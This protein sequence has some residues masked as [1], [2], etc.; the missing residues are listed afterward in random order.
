MSDPAEL[1]VT[2]YAVEA[3]ARVRRYPRRLR[4]NDLR[5]SRSMIEALAN[6][7]ATTRE[8]D[9]AFADGLNAA[10]ERGSLLQARAVQ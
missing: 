9:E 6:M 5:E 3:L 4:C 8:L 2:L 7:C 10:V 1:I